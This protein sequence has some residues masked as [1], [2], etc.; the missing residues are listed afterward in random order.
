MHSVQCA[1]ETHHPGRRTMIQSHI[2]RQKS[3]A[4]AG[5][6][7]SK[8]MTKHQAASTAGEH[9]AKSNVNGSGL[10]CPIGPQKAEYLSRFNPQG[11]SIQR[12]DR[13]PAKETS[14]FFGDVVEFKRGRHEE[15]LASGN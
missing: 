5:G 6:R 9:E 12:F 4:F 1:I 2:F 14:V 3:D 8:R 7:M 15:Q 10:P 13:F 11:K